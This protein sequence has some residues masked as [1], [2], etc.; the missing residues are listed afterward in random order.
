MSSGSSFN[1]IFFR[2]E[3]SSIVGKNFSMLILLSGILFFTFL[4]LGHVIGGREELEER[5]N[6][7][8]TNWINVPV[9]SQEEA[10]VSAFLDDF[11][12]QTKLDSFGIKSLTP[13]EITWFKAIRSGDRK[14]ISLRVR[15]MNPSDPL[16]DI[17]ASDE[18]VITNNIADTDFNCSIIISEQA[19]SILDYDEISAIKS[20]AVRDNELS[21]WNVEVVYPIRLV[22]KELPDKVHIIVS[23]NLMSHLN[24]S[25]SKTRFLDNDPSYK[26][27]FLAKE[28][29]PIESFSE[30]IKEDHIIEDI[31]Y[32]LFMYNNEELYKHTL[33]FQERISSYER[34]GLK[35]EISNQLEIINYYKH[36]CRELKTHINPY[37]YSF[38]FSRLDKVSEFRK[39]IKSNYDIDISLA[40]VESRNNFFLISRLARL[41]IYLLVIFSIAIILLFIQNIIKNHIE[42]IASNLGTLKA[43]GL[44]DKRITNLYLRIVIRY[45]VLSSIY[46]FVL[47]SFYYLI[48]K[49]VPGFIR[50]NL[51]SVELLLV[52]LVIFTSIFIFFKNLIG[53]LLSK[54]PGDLIYKR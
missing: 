7:P 34:Y 26:V 33:L 17:L 30:I 37:Y 15:S 29:L 1:S 13:Y 46:A 22:V 31:N 3:F 52:W 27:D 6:N 38:H 47:L 45:F 49:L 16:V 24:Q 11:D 8:F 54:T 25:N 39:Y 36:N 2:K 32:D 53:R 35:K 4:A 9:N 44:A 50:F 43:F 18:N 48:I 20:L 19:L 41:F 14:P 5:M 12:T 21:E 10:L 23:D 40:Q 51:F 42:K 28:K